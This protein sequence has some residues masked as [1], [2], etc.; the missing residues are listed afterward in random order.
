MGHDWVLTL[1]LEKYFHKSMAHKV[2]VSF[3]LFYQAAFSKSIFVPVNH[4]LCLFSFVIEVTTSLL[5]A[6]FQILLAFS[7]SHTIKSFKIHNGPLEKNCANSNYSLALLIA[8][9]YFNFLYFIYGTL[10]LDVRAFMT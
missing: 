7:V 3:E 4:F 5:W 10:F 9:N 8:P 6:C 2:I 1:N